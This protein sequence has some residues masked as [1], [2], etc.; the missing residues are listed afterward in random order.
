[1]KWFVFLSLIFLASCSSQKAILVVPSDPLLAECQVSPPPSL[2]GNDAKD[3]VILAGAWATQTSNLG[4]C[5]KRL[6]MLRVWKQVNLER[7][8]KN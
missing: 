3:K 5:N 2:T 7:Y 4:S 1:M 6:K 8:G